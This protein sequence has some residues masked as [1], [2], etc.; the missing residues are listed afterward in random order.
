MALS[1][2][3]TQAELN[4]AV[5]RELLD[6]T[7]TLSWSWSNVEINQYLEDWQDLLQD[8]FW[9][10]WNTA[11]VTNVTTA[12]L[13][14]TAIA[15]DMLAPGN[16]WF[17]DFRM[18]GRTKEELDMLLRDW[19]AVLPGSPE[20]C[21]QDTID[22]ISFWPPMGSAGTVIFEY[23][24]IVTFG[25]STTTP[26]SLPAWTRYSAINYCAYRAYMRPGPQ[27]DLARSA[28]YK[29]KFVRQGSRIRALW[30]MYFPD[31]APSLRP[32]GKYEGDIL[33]VGMHNTLFSCW[34]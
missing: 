12:T 10:V 1:D 20:A 15:T 28:R 34:F 26:M 13:T 17:N 27:Q 7:G 21:Y 33:T 30:D 5:R 23:P 6:P 9:F 11:T 25:T 2:L 14:L 3:W 4:A 8:H 19:R 31:R 22:T 24:R 18:K 32:G 29:A 16:I